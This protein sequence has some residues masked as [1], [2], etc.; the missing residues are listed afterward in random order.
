MKEKKNHY[1]LNLDATSFV[2]YPSVSVQ[3]MNLNNNLT[4]L[5]GLG[6]SIPI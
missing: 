4:G 1:F 2:L 5:L 3:S 6:Y